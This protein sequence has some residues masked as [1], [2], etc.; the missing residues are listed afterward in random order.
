MHRLC[1]AQP[2]RPSVR[3]QKGVALLGDHGMDRRDNGDA[4]A[5]I[6]VVPN[7]DFP[8]VLDGQIE[9]SEKVAADLRMLAI[10]EIHRALDK[11]ALPHLPHHLG[12][13][14]GTL[15]RFVFK[16]LV[17]LHVQVVGPQFDG[18]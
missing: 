9:I 8:I 1:V 12:Q 2:L 11:A 7:G 18:L 5:K 6:T 17:I 3:A 14:P 4:R 16:G 15:F 10:V 13:K